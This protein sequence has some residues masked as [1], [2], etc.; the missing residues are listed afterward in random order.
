MTTTSLSTRLDQ[1][2]HTIV[3][4]CAQTHTIELSN[5]TLLIDGRPA[6]VSI[7]STTEVQLTTEAGIACVASQAFW[8]AFAG[9]GAEP[10]AAEAGL[11]LADSLMRVQALQQMQRLQVAFQ[12]VYEQIQA[13][14]EI[15][16]PSYRLSPFIQ[17]ALDAYDGSAETTQLLA[18]ILK[19]D[20]AVITAWALS[21][22]KGQTPITKLPQ[23]AQNGHHSE[24]QNMTSFVSATKHEEGIVERTV[25]EAPRLQ[26]SAEM[27]EQLTAA[28]LASQETSIKATIVEVAER[29]TWPVSSVHGRVYKLKL[30]ERKRTPA[31]Q[32]DREPE[33]KEGDR[34]EA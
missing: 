12:H 13:L 1:V 8:H 20:E 18:R 29:F 19:Q 2:L 4:Q 5:D 9:A 25:V 10:T 11:L 26:W 17:Q 16:L 33:A 32:H 24:V 23:D 22:G 30:N 34:A 15:P 14:C 28:F 3:D 7:T 31:Q 21:L 27:D 6:T